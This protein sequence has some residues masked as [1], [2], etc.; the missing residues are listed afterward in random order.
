M[1]PRIQKTRDKR[2]SQIFE[3]KFK[4]GDSV[5]VLPDKRIGIVCKP[6]DASG[7]VLV[8]LP[9]GKKEIN[10]KRLCLH[11]KA[12]ELYPDDY[13]FSIIFDTVENR[14]ARHKMGKKYQP[15]LTVPAEET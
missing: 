1:G 8:Q 13:D 10:Q 4:R 9:E 7:R 15:G 5:Q 3:P 11:V 2:G 14:K 12:E 6:D